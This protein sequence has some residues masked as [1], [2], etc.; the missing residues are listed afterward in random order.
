MGTAREPVA[1]S[2]RCPA[3]KARVW[4][5]KTWSL[6]PLLFWSGMGL[7]GSLRFYLVPGKH[8]ALSSQH[9]ALSN[10]LAVSAQGPQLTLSNPDRRSQLG[11]HG[12]TYSTSG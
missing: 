2:G 4:K 11:Q 9:S 12:F 1:E 3:C 5:P 10:R 8:S 7:L 6:D